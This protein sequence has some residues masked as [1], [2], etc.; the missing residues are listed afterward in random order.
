MAADSDYCK[1][2]EHYHSAGPSDFPPLQDH[3]TDDILSIMNLQGD[4]TASICWAIRLTMR[5][6]TFNLQRGRGIL[7]ITHWATLAC[8]A[9]FLHPSA[10]ICRTIRLELHMSKINLQG[11]N[12]QGRAIGNARNSTLCW[13]RSWWMRSCPS[14]K[15][16]PTL[17][18]Q[19]GMILPQD[20]QP[21]EPRMLEQDAGLLALKPPR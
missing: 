1:Y 14:C 7:L 19:Q 8:W 3:T 12:L 21:C 17:A 13:L 2:T 16:H 15:A 6:S 5:Q 18:G 9:I 11:H 10:F 4:P 20:M